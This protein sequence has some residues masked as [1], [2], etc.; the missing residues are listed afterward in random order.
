MNLE[1]ADA[2]WDVIVIGG[3][4]TGGAVFLEAL[5]MGLKT[6]LLEQKDF[7]WG[8]S[9]KSSKMVHGGLRYLKEGRFLLTRASVRERQ[10][11]LAEAPGLVTP[12]GFLMPVYKGMGPSKLAMGLGLGVYSLMAGKKQFQSFSRT[13]MLSRAPFIES[14]GLSGG[15]YFEDA[16]VDD[17]RLVFRLIREGI[18][19]GGTALNYTRVSGIIRD[20][21]GRVTGIGAEDMESGKS[22]D[23]H[24]G[25]V[26]NATGAW[27]EALQPFPEKG[28]HIRPLRGSHLVF[29]QSLFPLNHV[30]SFI[31][32]ADQRPVFMFPWENTAILGTTDVD[33]FGDL[34]IEPKI[35]PK[36]SQYLLEGAAH[37]MPGLNISEKDCTASFAGIR[38]VLSPGHAGK[39]TSGESREHLVRD[40]HGLVTVTGG[41]LTTF[42]LLAYDA[43]KKAG[44]YLPPCRMPSPKEPVFEQPGDMGESGASLPSR[45]RERLLGR[46]GREAKHLAHDCGSDLLTEIP[47]TPIL[48][49]ELAYAAKHEQV[50]HLSDLM[51]RRTRLA[52]ILPF[53]GAEHFQKIE[54]ICKHNLGWDNTRWA[55]EKEAYAKEW[56]LSY[57]PP[58]KVNSKGE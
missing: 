27:A 24:A 46:Y 5:R 29:P 47:G 55:M 25:V 20:S 52:L 3:G 44:R 4:V 26:I 40:D 2:S 22:K 32:P 54:D 41:K 43:L 51:M 12:L 19:K 10:R 36:E 33:H 53:G 6:L 45:I 42:R 38:P 49:A 16:Q 30:L 31:H 13:A 58:E 35:T 17:A 28:L 23:V 21:R 18:G 8:T 15:F 57:A 50:V 37:V 1:H 39:S 14:H 7:A 34:N 9:G 11:L 56:E 48:W